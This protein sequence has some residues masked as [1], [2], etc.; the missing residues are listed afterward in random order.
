[1]DRHEAINRAIELFRQGHH[2]GEVVL[3][4]GGPLV[5]EDFDP[6][7]AR[8][9]TGWAGGVAHAEDLCGALAAGVMLIGAKHGRITLDDD[10]IV[11]LAKVR[12]FREAFRQAHGSLHCRDIR[13]GPFSPAA[14][15][16]CTAVVRQ[17]M[18]ALF[19]V[20]E[21]DDD[22]ERP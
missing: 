4:C 22:A 9:G 13:I 10:D 5:W 20:L 15:E 14:H 19:D 2:C 16:A 1:M 11:A 3:R 8:M 17:A 6:R 21:D 12:R 18:E 7:I